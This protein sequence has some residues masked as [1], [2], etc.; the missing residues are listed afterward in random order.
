MTCGVYIYNRPGIYKG[1]CLQMKRRSRKHRIPSEFDQPNNFF[2]NP[3]SP[4]PNK[5]TS[6]STNQ[7]LTLPFLVSALTSSFFHTSPSF[8]NELPAKSPRKVL[9]TPF[10]SEKVV[11]DFWISD[12]KVIEPFAVFARIGP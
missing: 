7:I 2:Q 8:P 1:T 10:F 4:P 5:L 9:C 12:E 3:F 6:S 11:R